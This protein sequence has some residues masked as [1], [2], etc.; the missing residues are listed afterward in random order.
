L[1]KYKRKRQVYKRFSLSLEQKWPDYQ[2]IP[3]VWN[4]K[5]GKI[6]FQEQ[7]TGRERLKEKFLEL[8]SRTT[9]RF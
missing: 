6:G 8:T 5:L 1:H 7:N 3:V 9:Q 2:P 4:T